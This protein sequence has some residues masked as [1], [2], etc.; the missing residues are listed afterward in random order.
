[1]LKIRVTAFSSTMVEACFFKIGNQL[2]K[3]ARHTFIVPLQYQISTLAFCLNGHV[4]S[5]F[6]D[7]LKFDD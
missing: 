7:E 1:M 6:G 3:F 5:G 2:T 4:D